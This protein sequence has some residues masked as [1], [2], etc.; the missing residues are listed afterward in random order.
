MFISTEICAMS[1]SI[2]WQTVPVFCNA[3]GD[4]TTSTQSLTPR[5]NAM[6]NMRAV[7]VKLNASLA[8]D[9]LVLE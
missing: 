1:R 6:V 2:Q 8:S 4:V 3:S 7:H 9:L 5:Q